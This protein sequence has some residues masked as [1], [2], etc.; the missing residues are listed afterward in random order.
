[1]GRSDY[2]SYMTNQILNMRLVLN[3]SILGQ[4]SLPAYTLNLRSSLTV[5]WTWGLTEEQVTTWAKLSKS[6]TY[7]VRPTV[8]GAFEAGVHDLHHLW[9]M[10][11]GG[12]LVIFFTSR[13]LRCVQRTGLQ[14]CMFSHGN[15]CL[16]LAPTQFAHVRKQCQVLLAPKTELGSQRE[17]S[18]PWK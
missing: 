18:C 13:T 3:S 2:S 11:R 1:M 10:Q 15:N 9:F 6:G 7:R 4:H 12:S 17:I 5:V 16:N 8:T 14:R